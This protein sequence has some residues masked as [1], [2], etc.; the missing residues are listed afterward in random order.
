[1]TLTVGLSDGASATYM[2]R[3]LLKEECEWFKKF[4]KGT[5]VAVFGKAVRNSGYSGN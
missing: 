3:T 1:M 5:H 2:K 4:K